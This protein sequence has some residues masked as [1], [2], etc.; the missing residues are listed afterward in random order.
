MLT[1][2]VSN[3]RL[4]VKRNIPGAEPFVFLYD[5]WRSYSRYGSAASDVH[6]GF[7][8]RAL[9]GFVFPGFGVAGI[10]LMRDAS[11][12]QYRDMKRVSNG[13]TAAYDGKP[14][15]TCWCNGLIASSDGDAD[16]DG[17]P[18]YYGTFLEATRGGGD[19]RSAQAAP[20]CA[21]TERYL[22]GWL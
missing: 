17:I 14:D 2:S 13:L 5:G 20:G 12:S 15:I 18:V 19:D 16:E 9:R 3:G 6:P 8:Y 11:Y 4:L 7:Y 22:D 10:P 1:I 21:G